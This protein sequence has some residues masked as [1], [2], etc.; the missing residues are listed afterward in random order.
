MILCSFFKEIHL[1]QRDDAHLVITLLINPEVF[2]A[3]S[4]NVVVAS[5]QIRTRI[6]HHEADTSAAAIAHALI[7]GR[8]DNRHQI[9]MSQH[10]WRVDDAVAEVFENAAHHHGVAI[11][12]FKYDLSPDGVFVAEMRVGKR[13]AHHTTVT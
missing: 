3:P 9:A 2:L 11:V 6:S 4:Q 12:S 10:I 7:V 1:T 5:L 8:V 13:L